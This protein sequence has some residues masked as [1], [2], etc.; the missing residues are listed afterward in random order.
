MARQTSLPRCVWMLWE[1]LTEM[2]SLLQYHQLQQEQQQVRGLIK[3]VYNILCTLKIELIQGQSSTIVSVHVTTRVVWPD[4]SPVLTSNW[5]Q[6]C[7]NN[8][9]CGVCCVDAV[10]NPIVHET[11]LF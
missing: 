2:M 4:F 1:G 11:G 5:L 6:C 9:P 7:V 10:S 8:H 3:T